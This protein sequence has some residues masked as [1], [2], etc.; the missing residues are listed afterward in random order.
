MTPFFWGATLFVKK[1]MLILAHICVTRSNY[2]NKTETE[3]NQRP[4]TYRIGFFLY[5]VYVN[6]PL[7]RSYFGSWDAL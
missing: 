6:C 2:I 7:L 3:Q 5:T 4:T 1:K